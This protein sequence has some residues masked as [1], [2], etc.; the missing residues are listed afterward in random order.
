MEIYD[1]A[2]VKIV[3]DFIAWGARRIYRSR[4]YS[5]IFV[6][7]VDFLSEIVYIVGN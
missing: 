3:K 6:R 1:G 4:A 5:V 7:A 2:S